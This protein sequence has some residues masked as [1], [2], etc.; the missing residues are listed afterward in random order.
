MPAN[1]LILDDTRTPDLYGAP[2]GLFDVPPHGHADRLGQAL[3]GGE[4]EGEGEEEEEEAEPDIVAP[5]GVPVLKQV[6]AVPSLFTWHLG[7]SWGQ[8][9]AVL[10]SISCDV[11][12]ETEL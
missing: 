6:A 7:R 8:S 10:F 2:E 4:D 9:W 5:D 3:E 1:L 12:T 11:S